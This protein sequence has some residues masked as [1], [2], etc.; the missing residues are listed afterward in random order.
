M[1]L[2]AA[3]HFRCRGSRCCR[4]GGR[5]R[6]RCRSADTAALRRQPCQAPLHLAGRPLRAWCAGLVRGSLGGPEGLRL[7]VG[8]CERV[9]NQGSIYTGLCDGGGARRSICGWPPG[10]CPWF[11]ARGADRDPAAPVR[12]RQAPAA[13]HGRAGSSESVDQPADQVP[14]RN[15][16]MPARRPAHPHP[17]PFTALPETPA[18]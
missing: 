11:A 13:G 6:S 8:I 7:H 3:A 14:A 1:S 15:P 10:L 9:T 4:A 12:V 2:R 17:P 16:R 18:R 5:L